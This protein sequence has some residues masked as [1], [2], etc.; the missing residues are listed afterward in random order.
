M[1]R[2]RSVTALAAATLAIASNVLGR[3]QTV[4]VVVRVHAVGH[5]PGDV[6][7]DAEAR[8]ARIFDAIGVPLRWAN[9]RCDCR[10]LERAHMRHIDLIV[11]SGEHDER[12]ATASHVSPQTLGLA[13]TAASRA[14]LFAAR[15][16]ELA[17]PSYEA[18]PVVLGRAMAHE[19]GHVLL[20]GTGHTDT[21]IMRATLDNG[22]IEDPGF[23]PSERD[24]ILALLTSG[25]IPAGAEEQS[26]SAAAWRVD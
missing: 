10:R 25:R 8:A 19:I 20:P 18:W 16:R 15:L 23:T 14:Y 17:A 4:G 22:G 21:G 13:A 5:M 26:K 9:D 12:F 3:D 7:H 6:L 2:A 1:C 24:T 11:L